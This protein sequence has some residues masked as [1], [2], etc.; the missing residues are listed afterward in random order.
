MSI[1]SVFT[2]T[3]GWIYIEATLELRIAD[4]GNNQNS[5]PR[6][7]SSLGVPHFQLLNEWRVCFVSDGKLMESPDYT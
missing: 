5:Q 7:N 1:L 2:G 3:F 4:A 6:L